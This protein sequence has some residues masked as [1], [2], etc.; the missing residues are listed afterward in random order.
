MLAN[1]AAVGHTAEEELVARLALTAPVLEAKI[2]EA[3]GHSHAPVV[4]EMVARRNAANHSFRVS[5]AQLASMS[6]PALN[7]AQRGHRPRTRRARVRCRTT[8]EVLTRLGSPCPLPSQTALAMASSKLVA[9][10]QCWSVVTNMAAVTF[11]VRRPRLS[12]PTS[13]RPVDSYVLLFIMVM[14][15]LFVSLDIPVVGVNKQLQSD[16]GQTMSYVEV[17]SPPLGGMLLGDL[18]D[19]V[20]FDAHLECSTQDS[21]EVGEFFDECIANKYIDYCDDTFRDD[22]SQLIECAEQLGVEQYLLD[23]DGLDAS[24]GDAESA[25]GVQALDEG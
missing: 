16:G 4:P 15:L 11:G 2:L 13:P 19:D 9:W 23:D 25:A 1:V 3:A 10:Q 18:L 12:R 24:G 6:R 7:A 20:I 14:L 21:A 8:S 5:A 22:A 17:A